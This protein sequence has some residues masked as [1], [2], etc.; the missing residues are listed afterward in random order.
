VIN[1]E[2]CP[3]PHTSLIYPNYLQLG[4]LHL[5]NLHQHWNWC[6]SGHLLAKLTNDGNDY[7]THW[8]QRSILTPTWPLAV[9]HPMTHTHTHWES[10]IFLI[11]I[12]V[13]VPIALPTYIIK[14]YKK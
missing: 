11:P 9:K 14:E 10:Q 7:I 1:S 12:W 6:Y 5:F 3:A 13:W 2:E 8:G 4:L